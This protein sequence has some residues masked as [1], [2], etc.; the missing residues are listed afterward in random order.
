MPHAAA[1]AQ[2]NPARLTPTARLQSMRAASPSFA[3]SSR[4]AGW[5][6]SCHG[7]V[8][9]AQRVLVGNFETTYGT[10]DGYCASIGRTCTGAW[11]ELGDSCLV[12]YSMDRTT[13]LESSD[14]IC[15]CTD[16]GVAPVLVGNFETTYGTC[17]GYC[18]SIGRTCTGAWDELGDSCLVGYSMECT[19][20]LES[21]DAI[22]ECTDTGVAP[23]M[24]DASPC[25]TTAAR[26]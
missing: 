15:E 14:A 5:A 2:L 3:S 4:R 19:T 25:V 1:E 8:D 9:G 6:G 22:C 21:S 16:T 17:D 7:Q 23:A 13:R 26:Q 20:R 11:D 18:A 24:N 10:C 12:G